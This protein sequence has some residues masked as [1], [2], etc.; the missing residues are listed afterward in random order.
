MALAVYPSTA[1]GTHPRAVTI[2]PTDD[3]QAS[4]ASAVL[5]AAPIRAPILLSGSSGLPTA[6]RDALGALSPSGAGAV[7]GGG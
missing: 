3:W 5:M 2:A 4:I 1:S 7:G 6:T